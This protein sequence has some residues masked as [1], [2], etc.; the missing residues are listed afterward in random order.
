MR[1]RCLAIMLNRCQMTLGITVDRRS[2]IEYTLST[3]AGV[4]SET[5]VDA[6]DIVVC[7][8][9]KTNINK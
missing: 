8:N 1:P 6:K 2:K 3:W 4:V 5:Q 9:W 7:S